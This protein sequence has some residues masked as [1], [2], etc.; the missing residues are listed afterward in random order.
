[1]SSIFRTYYSFQVAQKP[2]IT[3]NIVVMAIGAMTELGI[4][5]IV[6]CAPVLPRFFQQFGPKVFNGSIIRSAA[7]SGTKLRSGLNESTNNLKSRLSRTSVFDKLYSPGPST[8]FGSR[9]DLHANAHEMDGQYIAIDVHGMG[10]SESRN[11]NTCAP[12]SPAAGQNL[13]QQ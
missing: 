12:T 4:G 5:I 11:S 13:I 9:N 3:F 1:M 6:S 2:D 7:M 10:S 8:R